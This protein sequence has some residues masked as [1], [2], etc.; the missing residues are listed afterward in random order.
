MDSHANDRRIEWI[1]FCKFIAIFYMVWGHSGTQILLDK[2][3]HVFHMP[4]FFFL[5][6]YLFDATRVKNFKEF[7]MKKI[8]TLLVPYFLFP[9]V[10]YYFWTIAY[11]IISKSNPETQLSLWKG[12]F[13]VNAIISPF[14]AVQWFLTCLFLV[15]I[16]FYIIIKTTKN[17]KISLSSMLILLSLMGYFYTSVIHFRL[18]WGLDIAL[19]ALVFYGLGYL[20]KNTKYNKIKSFV[21]SPSIFKIGM[22]FILSIIFTFSNG[23]VNMRTLQYSNYFLYFLSS[24][25]SIIMYIMLAIYISKIEKF[26]SSK[27]QK[28]LLYIGQNTIIVLVLNQLYIQSLRHVEKYIPILNGNIRDIIRAVIVITLMGPTAYLINKYFPFAVGRK[29]NKS[30]TQTNL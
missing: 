10:I 21:L 20:F 27:L 15:E 16:I 30:R 18:Y 11:G 25:T 6:G 4:I 19:T 7:L 17:N 24:V 3:I 5:S 26:S 13:T 14:G 2:Y 1:D 9:I 8:R 29:N 28:Y 23:Y 12:I 22:F